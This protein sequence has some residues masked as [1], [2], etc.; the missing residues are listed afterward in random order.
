MI[1]KA[2]VLL[3]GTWPTI[4]TGSAQPENCGF[5]S[6]SYYKSRHFHSKGLEKH[7]GELLFLKLSSLLLINHKPT[8]IKLFRAPPFKMF[9]LKKDRGSKS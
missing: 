6:S 4:P 3:E 5:A 7:L 9:S 1:L 2:E 8:S